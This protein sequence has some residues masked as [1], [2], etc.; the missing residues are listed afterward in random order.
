MTFQVSISNSK[1]YCSACGTEIIAGD[2]YVVR[3]KMISSYPQ[4]VRLCRECGAELFDLEIQ[5]CM[6]YKTML[7]TYAIPLSTRRKYVRKREKDYQR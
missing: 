6:H 5:K 4:E 1:F 2:I 7:E 3:T